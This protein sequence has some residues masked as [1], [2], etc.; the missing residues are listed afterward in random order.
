MFDNIDSKIKGLAVLYTIAG[1]I[2]SIAGASYYF[3]HGVA[4]IG[5]LIL[6]FL[7]YLHPG[8]ALFMLY[9]FGELISKTTKK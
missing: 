8:S 1:I 9:G 7:V 2:G 3:I 4:L 6:I 5:F